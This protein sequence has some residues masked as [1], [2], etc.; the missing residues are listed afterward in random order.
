M[1]REKARFLSHAN[2]QKGKDVFEKYG[3]KSIFFARM[4]GPI[5]WLVPF[6][7]GMYKIPYRKFI[8]YNIPGVVVG[9][10]QFIVVGYFFGN[11]YKQ[12]LGVVQEY[13]AGLLG[14]LVVLLVAYYV[15]KNYFPQVLSPFGRLWRGVVGWFLSK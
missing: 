15:T 6:L 2:Y 7:A 10:G 3:L 11:Q 12:I 1:F 14:G 9:I 13:G 5:S 8:V 4:L